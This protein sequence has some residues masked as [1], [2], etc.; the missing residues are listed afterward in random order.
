VTP[1][2]LLV[3]LGRPVGV[4]GTTT[5]N[6]SDK[7][8]GVDLSAADLVMTVDGATANIVRSTTSN[9]T[10]AD[11]KYAE[12]TARGS[13]DL[14]IGMATDAASLSQMLGANISGIGYG[15]D[16]ALVAGG[17]TVASYSPYGLGDVIGIANAAGAKKIW[18]S[19]NGV[20]LN[21]DPSAGTGG[22]EYS[23]F[24]AYLSAGAANGSG[25]EL[26]CGQEP[27]VYAVPSGFSPWG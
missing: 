13:A 1:A 25:A 16:G 3:L 7:G 20:W 22:Y 26:N 9:A 19:L 11:K 27:F 21:G 14:R 6:P 2:Q 12:L 15:T 8:A 17:G 18:W 5:W 24:V 10:G 4:G 23:A